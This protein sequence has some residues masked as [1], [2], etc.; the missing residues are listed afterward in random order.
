MLIKFWLEVSNDEQKRRFEARIDDPLAAVE[1]EPDGPAVTREVVRLLARA[2]IAML[3][4][5]DTQDAPWYILRSDDKKRARLN[6]IAHILSQIPYKKLPA[7]KI[8]AARPG[9]EGRLRRREDDQ[10]TA[11]REGTVLGAKG[12]GRARA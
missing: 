6:A 4:A 9:D 2:A 8:D 3:K 5:T 1:A 10:A 11:V 12:R 7:P